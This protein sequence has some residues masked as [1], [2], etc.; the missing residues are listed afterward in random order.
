MIPQ[1]KM[2]QLVDRY[3][4]LQSEMASDISPDD[5]VKLAKEYSELTPVVEVIRAMEAATV[6]IADLEELAAG[7]KEFGIQSFACTAE[8]VKFLQTYGFHVKHK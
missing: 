1:G 6:E 5:Y 7:F 8:D 4:A 2:G 3:E